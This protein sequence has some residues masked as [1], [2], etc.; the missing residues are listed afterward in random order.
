[1]EALIENGIVTNIIVGHVYNS[2]PIEEVVP[3]LLPTQIT[4][5][6]TYD[7][8]VDKVVKVYTIIDKPIIIPQSITALQGLL[9]IDVAGLS[10]AYEAWANGAAR[11]FAEKAFINRAQIWK[12]DDATLLSAAA[13][14]GLTD[15][16]LDELFILGATL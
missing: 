5:G 12:R 2:L 3:T 10:T 14:F 11:T 13:L 7:I 8:Q 15:L 16:Q 6:F 4:N 1:M 9:A